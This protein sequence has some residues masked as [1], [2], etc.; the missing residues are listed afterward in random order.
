MPFCSPNRPPNRLD[1]STVVAATEASGEDPPPVGAV[2]AS[3]QTPRSNDGGVRRFG[4]LDLRAGG[5][6][7]SQSRCKTKAISSDDGLLVFR[8]VFHLPRRSSSGYYSSDGDSMPSSPLSSRPLT[9]DRATQTPSPTG[10]VMNHAMQRMAEARGGGLGTPQ[11]HGELLE[12][13][14]L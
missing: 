4:R 6:P 9:A 11:Q 13:C 10:Q 1:G 3:A 2:G 7:D 8:S 5:E 14:T 12:Y